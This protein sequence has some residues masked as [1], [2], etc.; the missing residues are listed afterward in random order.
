MNSLSKFF[1]LTGVNTSNK[2]LLDVY[3]DPKLSLSDK[4][5]L[6]E[7]IGKTNEKDESLDNDVVNNT[8]SLT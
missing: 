4:L 5:L 6:E 2:T 7:F 8:S 1:A 3:A